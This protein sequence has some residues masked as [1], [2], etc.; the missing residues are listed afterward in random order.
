MLG[1]ERWAAYG[2]FNA[3][4]DSDDLKTIADSCAL[5]LAL[6]MIQADALQREL[7][8]E[9]HQFTSMLY[10]DEYDFSGNLIAKPNPGILLFSDGIGYTGALYSFLNTLKSFLDIYAKLMGKL[11]SR[12][13]CW[14]FKRAK[15]GSE[16]IAGGTLINWLLKSAPSTYQN[17]RK[18]AA[19]TT[20][21]SEE[22]ITNL[23]DY[24]D[25]ISHY[26]DIKG[27]QHMQ[28]TLIPSKPCFIP[29]T[30]SLPKMPDGRELNVYVS[31]ILTLL[32]IFI[33]ESIVIL[34]NVDTSNINV[35]KLLNR[36]SDG[37]WQ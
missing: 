16:I 24:R 8:R 28:V 1:P 14:T 13:L 34:P 11:I 10:I 19:I 22:W 4:A 29:S 33:S 21:C 30:I 23:V 36:S 15:V 25:T 35:S 26:S 31:D 12:Q 37:R 27:F 32:K 5:R 17:A 9:L 20:R 2:V 18:L 7:Q 3:N 6:L